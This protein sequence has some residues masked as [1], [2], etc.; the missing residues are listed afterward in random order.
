MNLYS[1]PLDRVKLRRLRDVGLGERKAYPSEVFIEAVCF[2]PT[3]NELSQMSF[4]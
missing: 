2:L 1:S 3:G 4:R